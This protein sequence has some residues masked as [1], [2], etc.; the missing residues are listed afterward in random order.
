M[1]M[2]GLAAL[3]MAILAP[4]AAITIS[5]AVL[6]S[7]QL[8]ASE[9]RLVGQV[10]ETELNLTEQHREIYSNTRVLVRRLGL[11]R[12]SL[13]PASERIGDD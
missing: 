12:G 6:L 4:M 9:R 2:Y 8:R 10:R 1:S 11:L 5:F 7:N 13:G 3:I